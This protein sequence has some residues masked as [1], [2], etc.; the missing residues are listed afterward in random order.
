MLFEAAVCSIAERNSNV[1]IPVQSLVQRRNKQPPEAD[2]EQ[3]ELLTARVEIM[4]ETLHL[5]TSGRLLSRTCR[6]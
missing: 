2:V 6:V 3:V 1:Q 5:Y 4:N